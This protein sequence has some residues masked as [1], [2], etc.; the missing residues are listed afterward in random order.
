MS[1]CLINSDVFVRLWFV[2]KVSVCV[3]LVPCCHRI[4]DW[5]Q[6]I[7]FQKQ[8]LI[9]NKKAELYREHTSRVI[10]ATWYRTLFDH[11]IQII[12]LFYPKKLTP[13]HIFRLFKHCGE[14]CRRE[15][16]T[17]F[18]REFSRSISTSAKTQ[19]FVVF[20]L[21][22]LTL[23]ILYQTKNQGCLEY[24]SHTNTFV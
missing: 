12:C 5:I 3:C 22:M 8:S 16:K 14:Y 18:T 13:P 23:V 2:F 6:S 20:A 1:F 7:I 21:C 19:F 10:Y 24:T 4:S 11:F 9:N 15:K 17:K